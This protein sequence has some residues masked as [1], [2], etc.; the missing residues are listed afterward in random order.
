[1]S[2]STYKNNRTAKF[3]QTGFIEKHSVMRRRQ[4]ESQDI[5]DQATWNELNDKLGAALKVKDGVCEALCMKWIQLQI[6]SANHAAE[7]KLNL[8]TSVD[9]TDLTWDVRMKKDGSPKQEQI[10]YQS[11]C[12][13]GGERIAKL[14]T[15]KNFSK[16]I[17][18]QASAKSVVN[19]SLETLQT[20][21]SIPR[22]MTVKNTGG[23][24]KT[25]SSLVSSA[26]G[27]CF[28]LSIMCPKQEN[29]LHAI[30][31]YVANKVVYLFD[32]NV[33]EYTLEQH[34]LVLFI[35]CLM[36]EKYGAGDKEI[37]GLYHWG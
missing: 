36:I 16:A 13:T 27:A 15:E 14:S 18:R 9:T 24:I 1:M 30:A 37:M 28:M 31:L 32:P 3:N 34:D 10:K 23:G 35:T 8:R 6:K 7:P 29:G 11:G 4:A 17:D 22:G 19:Y 5:P 25:V 26:V 20:S 12:E 2:L 33:G 21:Y